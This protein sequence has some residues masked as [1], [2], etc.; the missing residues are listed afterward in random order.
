MGRVTRAYRYRYYPTDEQQQ[1]LARTFGCARWIYNWALAH[2]SRA[3]REEG[4][5]LSYDD[6]SACL[7]VLKRQEETAWLAEV[8]SVPLQQSLRHLERAFV[9][10]FEGRANYP[11]FKSK[12]RKVQSAT[13]TPAAFTYRDGVLTLAKM[14]EPLDIRWSRPLPQGAIP[15]RVTVS[16]DS[17]CRYFV[18]LL[19]EEEIEPLP[20]SS[21]LI[22]VDLG[23]TS[24]VTTS[25]GDKVGNPRFFTSNEKKLAGA[26]KR[27]TR[28][29]RYSKNREKARRKVARIHARI[30]DR[31][32]DYQHQLSTRLIRENQVIC[33]ESLA[34]KNMLQNRSLAKVIADVGW[35]EF[36]RQ[37]EYKA[38]WYG[39]TLIKIDRWFPSSKT[40]S[41]CGYLLEDLDLA[42]REWVCPSCG[43]RHDRDVNAAN[44]VLA[45]GL[46]LSAAGLAV[47]LPEEAT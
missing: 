3:Y 8:S 46:R 33:V 1:I 26:Q 9:N 30:A 2:K 40:C 45:E 27:L 24:M 13:Y 14:G 44:A 28:K 35:G 18:S 36:V 16:R 5:R 6:L 29:R 10:F 11:C 7:P 47:L 42:V 15:S 22:G 20:L 37:L 41:C 23:L 12:K 31:R 21:E 39:R 43:S 17:A 4:K 32:R 25:R 34:V 19:V 38:L